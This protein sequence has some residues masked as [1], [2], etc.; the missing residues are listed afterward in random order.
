MFCS[1]CGA[2]DQTGNFCQMCGAEVFKTPPPGPAKILKYEKGLTSILISEM[3]ATVSI[4]PWEKHETEFVITGDPDLIKDFVIERNGEAARLS[5]R[6]PTGGSSGGGDM[7]SGRVI[8]GDKINI[9]NVSGVGIAIGRNAGTIVQNYG[10]GGA[11]VGGTIIVNGQVISSGGIVDERKRLSVVIKTAYSTEIG[12]GKLMGECTI[13]DLLSR[14][15]L[16]LQATTLVRA[17]KSVALHAHLSSSA[18]AFIESVRDTIDCQVS[19][20]GA[21]EIRGGETEEVTAVV[22][23]SG[24]FVHRGTATKRASLQASSSGHV[25]L[26]KSLVPV[27]KHE[28]SSGRVIVGS[29]PVSSSGFN[30]F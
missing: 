12:V 7:V 14:L 24:Q 15:D 21:L 9:G 13:G 19:S 23:S 27:V 8:M 4:E 10:Q 11:V 22:S 5:C 3:F 30:S 28:S 16:R 17:G 29:E 2:K 1:R 20:S 18:T 26:Q 6:I 25:S